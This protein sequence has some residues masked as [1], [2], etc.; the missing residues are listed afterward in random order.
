[1]NKILAVNDSLLFSLVFFFFPN[2]LPNFLQMTINHMVMALRHIISLSCRP[3]CKLERSPEKKKKKE[4]GRPHRQSD[5]DFV[6]LSLPILAM[7]RK[8]RKH[9]QHDEQIGAPVWV[10]NA[11][12]VALSQQVRKNKKKE[13]IVLCSM[14]IAERFKVLSV[15]GEGEEKKKTTKQ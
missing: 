10:K 1:M 11:V 7:N 4:L 13:S 14:R 8:E 15:G 5:S 6:F 12:N 2:K 3:Q 9:G